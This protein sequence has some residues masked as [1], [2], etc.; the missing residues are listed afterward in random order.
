MKLQVVKILLLVTM[1]LANYAAAGND[2]GVKLITYKAA[3]HEVDESGTDEY[4]CRLLLLL[5]PVLR[6][7]VLLLSYGSASLELEWLD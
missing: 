3:Y 1:L 6:E 2:L 4:V 5:V 7:K